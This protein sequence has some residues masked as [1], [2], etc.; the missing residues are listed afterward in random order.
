[1][2]SVLMLIRANLEDSSNVLSCFTKLKATFSNS[3]CDYGK[4]LNCLKKNQKLLLLQI[5]IAV[6]YN[7]I[8]KRSKSNIQ[9]GCQYKII[10]N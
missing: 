8:V 10:I 1:M 3:I 9:Y 6:T 4:W 5:I 2:F 7:P